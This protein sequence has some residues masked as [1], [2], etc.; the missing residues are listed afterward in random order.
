MHVMG[1]TAAYVNAAQTCGTLW[2]QGFLMIPHDMRAFNIMAQSG[3][4][5]AVRF[6]RTATG[7][8]D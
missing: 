7:G 8:P 4:P 1:S 6:N 3:P 5:V 2:E